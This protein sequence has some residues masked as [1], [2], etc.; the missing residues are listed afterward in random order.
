[1]SEIE[2][3]YVP[4]VPEPLPVP[5]QL[6]PQPVYNPADW[7]W[8]VGTDRSRHWSSAAGGWVNGEPNADIGYTVI[9][10]VQLLCDVLAAYGLAKPLPAVADYSAAIQAHLDATA[11]Q[12]QYDGILSAI[13]Y[14]DDPNPVFAA[15]AEALFVWRSAVWTAA[16]AMLDGLGNGMPPAVADVIAALPAFAWPE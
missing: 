12:R 2:A 6:P 5:E 14:R 7:R 15:E 11:S 8:I 3:I 9:D 4:P 1:M 10:T 16:T 13:T